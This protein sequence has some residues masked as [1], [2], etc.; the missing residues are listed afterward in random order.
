MKTNARLTENIHLR[1]LTKKFRRSPTQIGGF[2]ESDAELIR[3]EDG[4][5]LALSTDSV[6]EEIA[7]GLYTDPAQIGWMTVMVNLSDL[8]A[9]GAEPLGILLSQTFPPNYPAEQ[10]E[11]LQGGIAEACDKAGVCVLGGDTN[12]SGVLQMGGTAIG[13]IKSG[14]IITRK[15]IRSGDLLYVS[16]GMGIGAAYAFEVLMS[17]ASSPAYRPCARLEEGQIVR[18]SGSSCMDTS[19]GFFPALCNLVE[20]NQLVFTIT[21]PFSEFTHPDAR[22]VASKNAIPDWFFLAG[23]HGEY[24][25]IFTIPPENELLFLRHATDIGWKPLKIGFATASES[26]S[27]QLPTG[28]WQLDPFQIANQYEASNGDPRTLLMNLIKKQTSWQLP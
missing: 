24:E 27:L 26:C 15:G 3:L 12:T 1:N 4:S 9:V 8:A 14:P 6:V 13:I 10:Q 19:D 18:S 25:L 7:A 16:G 20:I 17:G 21:C 23:P 28:T 11:A 22:M 2:L 5:V